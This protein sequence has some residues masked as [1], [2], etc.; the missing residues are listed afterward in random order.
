VLTA[1]SNGFGDVEAAA[2]RLVEGVE[3]IC[4]GRAV[5]RIAE[6]TQPVARWRDGL[7]GT[8]MKS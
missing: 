2:A 1:Q 6:R 4:G 8:D 5:V 7:L 3:R